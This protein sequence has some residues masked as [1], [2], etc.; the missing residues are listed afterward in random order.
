LKKIDEILANIDKLVHEE[1]DNFRKIE[2]LADVKMT[3]EVKE[4]VIRKL[5]DLGAEE[6]LDS[7]DISTNKKHKLET[8]YLDLNGELTTK[9]DSLWG[10]FSGVTK[11]TTHS[12]KKTDNTENKIFGPVGKREREIWSELVALV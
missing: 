5:F 7:D 11:Y 2:R 10:L 4:M 1:Q 3:K 6:K 8:F 9:E 12:M